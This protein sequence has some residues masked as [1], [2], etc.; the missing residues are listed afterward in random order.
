MLSLASCAFRDACKLTTRHDR[1]NADWDWLINE[2]AQPEKSSTPSLNHCTTYS[3]NKLR[4][5]TQK[6][7]RAET[8]QGGPPPPPPVINRVIGSLNWGSKEGPPCNPG[9]KNKGPCAAPRL[10][11]KGVGGVARVERVARVARAAICRIEPPA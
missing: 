5:A 7:L 4:T 8:Q 2:L 9:C 3:P 11:L 10:I 6:V 1:C